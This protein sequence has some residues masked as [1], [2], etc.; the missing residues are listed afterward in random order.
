MTLTGEPSSST[1]PLAT[2]ACKT[3]EESVTIR[4]PYRSRFTTRIS[5]LA[6]ACASP[7][8]SP[9]T[10]STLAS[11]ATH[12][13]NSAWL[14]P[15]EPE[16]ATHSPSDDPV[17]PAMHM[18]KCF[19]VLPAGPIELAGHAAHA[20]VPTAAL[21]SPALHSRH[22]SLVG[23]LYPAL[24]SH[25]ALPG[26]DV[27]PEGQSLPA[28]H[29]SHTTALASFENDPDKHPAHDTDPGVSLNAPATHGTQ[30][31]PS[32]PLKPALQLQFVTSTLS[33]GE[34]LNGG[35]AEHSTAPGTA[36]IPAGHAVHEPD[37]GT[38]LKDPA[39]HSAHGSGPVSFLNEPAGHSTQTPPS[40]PLKLESHRQSV[41]SALSGGDVLFA[42]QAEHSTAPAAANIPAGHA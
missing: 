4:W 7:S 11:E 26:S 28:G 40:G 24:H 29:V 36:Y 5:K 3:D 9:S 33:G 10:S 39:G 12:G 14:H 34:V 16:H 6:P 31:P 37:P 38:D 20:A 32:G 30:T 35:H 27:E 1:A 13:P 2:S 21:Y 23:P 17:K 22:C 41:T 25:T 15:A 18:H 42:G 19:P 8:P